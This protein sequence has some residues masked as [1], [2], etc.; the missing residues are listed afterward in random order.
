MT[1]EDEHV[2]W[3]FSKQDNDKN[4]HGINKLEQQL[5]YAADCNSSQLG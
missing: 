5:V 3:D 2:N 1:T 4:K